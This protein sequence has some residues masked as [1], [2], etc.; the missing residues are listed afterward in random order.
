V[1][2]ASGDSIYPKVDIGLSFA[3][4]GDSFEVFEDFIGLYELPGFDTL[5]VAVATLDMSKRRNLNV[6]DSR[7]EAYDGASTMSG[8]IAG[9]QVKIRQNEPRA[10]Y[11]HNIAH[12]LELNLQ[13]V[14]YRVPLFRDFCTRQ[15]H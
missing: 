5:D 11:G 13:D 2:N 6:N 7:G 12:K 15:T 3:M 4:V 1:I 8:D 14:M 9:V 10:V